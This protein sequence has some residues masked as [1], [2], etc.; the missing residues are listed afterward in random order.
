MGTGPQRLMQK[1]SQSNL[2]KNSRN[3]Y[4]TYI[5]KKGG[6]DNIML[7]LMIK[8]TKNKE[9]HDKFQYLEWS[10]KVI[11]ENVEYVKNQGF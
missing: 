5:F 7:K 4:N 6:K 1:L 9:N 10:S 2:L 8:N 3:R 11:V